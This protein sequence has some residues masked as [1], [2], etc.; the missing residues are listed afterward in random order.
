LSFKP[1]KVMVKQILKI[2]EAISIDLKEVKKELK[3][4]REE[5]K[6]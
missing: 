4:L 6:K 3:E 5:L 1:E 2:V